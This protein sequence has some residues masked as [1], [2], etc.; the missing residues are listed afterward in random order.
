MIR[1]FSKDLFIMSMF[2]FEIIFLQ[3]LFSF[4]FALLL[5]RGSGFN[6]L[7]FCTYLRS[8]K[9]TAEQLIRHSA[10]VHR[11]IIHLPICPLF[12][13]IEEISF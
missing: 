8:F 2:H 6:F 10:D 11:C 13:I 9:I 1:L 7:Q 12:F 3:T 5:F 4:I